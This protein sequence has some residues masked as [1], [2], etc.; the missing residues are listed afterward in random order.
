MAQ[1]RL[2]LSQVNPTVGDIAGNCDLVRRWTA[3]AAQA[4]AHLVAFPEMVVTG[5][6]VEDLALRDSFV[7]ASRSAVDQLARDLA[8]DGYGELPVVVGY[9]DRAE[10]EEADVTGEGVSEAGAS[11]VPKGMAQNCVAVLHRGEVAAQYAKHHLPNYGVFDEFR[12]FVP[13]GA[14]TVVEVAGVDVALAICEDLWQDGGPVAATRDAGAQL[15]LVVN[16]SPYERCKDDVRLELVRRRAAEAGCA[17]AYLNLVGAQ[18]DLVFDGGSLVVDAAGA[19]LAR[20]PQFVE[21]LLIVDL[22]LPDA[23]SERTAE[24]ASAPSGSSRSDVPV[25]RVTVSSEPVPAYEPQ[26]APCAEPLDDAE[27]VYRALVT[28]LGDYVRKN[29]FRQVLLG[30][31]GG[32]DSALVAAIAADAIGGE[33]V[34]GVSMPSAYSSEHSKGDAAELARRIGAD[35]RI[36]PIGAMVEA[37]LQNMKLNGVAEENLQARARGVVLMGISNM[38]GQLVLATGNKSELS[39]GYS[40]IYGDTAGG[41]APLKDV[42]KSLVWELSRW[43]NDEAKRRGETPPIPENS[44][45]KAP[46]AE[47]K[48]GQVD[49]DSLPPYDQLDPLLDAYVGDAMGRSELIAAGFDEAMVDRVVTMVDRAEWKRRQYAPGPKISRVAFG[50]DRRL[51]V[52]SR[53]RESRG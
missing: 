37:F 3:Q 17:L 30:L 26:Q 7:D 41:F 24:S 18:D 8:E 36:Q 21:N 23:R 34:V 50:R 13:G 2:A 12:I 43:R 40:T 52:T 25:R 51:P 29:G 10:G 14:L 48:P 35:F 5:Y 38:E 46:S 28:G 42:P 33:N 4:G 20:G 9:L 6:P 47:L 39:V 44:I 22:D 49:Q 53:W 27:E 16:G 45:T 31:S 15:L 32:I 19:V 11:G 1:L